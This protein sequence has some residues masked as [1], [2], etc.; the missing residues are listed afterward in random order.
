MPTTFR[1]PL[2]DTLLAKFAIP[3]TQ[4]DV[5]T[6]RRPLTDTSFL[7]SVLEVN[8]PAPAAAKVPP[9]DTLFFSIAAFST[10]TV[11][12]NVAAPTAVTVL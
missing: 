8:V 12:L 10:V 2:T 9:T 11:D 4:T 7:N 6:S 3:P 5:A 1:L